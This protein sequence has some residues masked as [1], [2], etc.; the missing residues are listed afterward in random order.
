MSK[1]SLIVMDYRVRLHLTPPRLYFP[2]YRMRCYDCGTALWNQI[3]CGAICEARYWSERETY[4]LSQGSN[5]QPGMDTHPFLGQDMIEHLTRI[6]THPDASVNILI[7]TPSY[8]TSL[9]PLRTLK[10]DDYPSNNPSGC[11][12]CKYTV[13]IRC[14]SVKKSRP[15]KLT[16]LDPWTLLTRSDIWLFPSRQSQELLQHLVGSWI[17]RSAEFKQTR[18]K[19]WY[20]NPMAEPTMVRLWSMC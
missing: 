8:P 3:S 18:M 15:V 9:G 10:F 16:Y 7:Y 11:H 17:W 12:I 1:M 6:S 4:S 19:R 20:T 14:L 13:D 2:E 5:S